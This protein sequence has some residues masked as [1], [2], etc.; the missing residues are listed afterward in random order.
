MASRYPDFDREAA[1]LDDAVQA[2]ERRRDSLADPDAAGVGVDAMTQRHIRGD[3]DKELEQMQPPGSPAAFGR[4]DTSSGDTWYIGMHLIMDSE[5]E[6]LVVSW[7]TDIARP[8]YEASSS[9]PRGLTRKREFEYQPA[10]TILRDIEDTHFGSAVESTAV[11]GAQNAATE[12]HRANISDSLLEELTR[13]RTGEMGDIVRTIAKTQSEVIRIE[14]GCLLVI[15]GGPGTGKTAVV[16]HRLSW[17]LFE[18]GLTDTE[19]LVIGPNRAFLKYIEQVL[20]ALGNPHIAQVDIQSLS[21]FA[22]DLDLSPEH[23]RV[24]ALKGSDVMAAVLDKAVEQRIQVPPEDISWRGSGRK[25]VVSAEAVRREVSRLSGLPY[26]DR[27]RELRSWLSQLAEEAGRGDAST[28]LPHARKTLDEVMPAL[29]A[30][31][32]VADLFSSKQRIEQAA[33]G[34]LSDS[35]VDLLCWKRT[36]ASSPQPWSASDLPLLDYADRI[37]SADLPRMYEHIVVDEAQDLSPMQLRMVDRRSL[38]GSITLA[39]DIAQSTGPFARQSWTDVTETLVRK[40]PVVTRE[41]EYGYRIPSQIYAI[42]QE[43]LPSIAPGLSPPTPVRIGPSEPSLIDAQGNDHGELVSREVLRL[44]ERPGSIGIIANETR[45]HGLKERLGRH[46][47]AFTEVAT[48]RVGDAINL[49]TPAQAKGLE[50]DAVIVVEPSEIAFSS[51]DGFRLL[52]IALTRATQHL[53][54]ISSD[55]LLPDFSQ[56]V[57]VSADLLFAALRSSAPP[58]LWEAILRQVAQLVSEAET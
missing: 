55:G 7:H 39:G 9:D 13:V 34:V 51:H 33:G 18:R 32:L 8:Y 37:I 22:D 57:R 4:I 16:L 21:R 12:A 10:S 27:R 58:Q 14:P 49:M 28:F 3:L 38:R 29:T 41:L 56:K 52:Y 36:G 40:V 48:G 11:Q 54:V 44:A 50:F 42:A 43:L 20:P 35:E 25:F 15:Q 1:Y 17:L 6:P 31:R 19:V 30:Q 5:S 24:A 47:V 23:E 2:R 26:M 45:V 46:N 53:T